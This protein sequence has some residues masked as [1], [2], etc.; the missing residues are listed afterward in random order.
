M[1]VALATASITL[2]NAGTATCNIQR[3]LYTISLSGTWTGTVFLQ[4]AFIAGPATQ[5]WN[6]VK[7]YTG[8]TQENGEAAEDQYVRLYVK[9]GG[10]GSGT[11]EARI[12]Q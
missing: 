7:A 4:R 10:F 3:G 2:S 5:N 1:A 9:N 8:A 6:D 11:I 12:S